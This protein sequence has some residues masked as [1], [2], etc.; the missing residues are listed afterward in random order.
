[1]LD[2]GRVVGGFFILAAL[3]SGPG[4]VLSVRHSTVEPS[5]KTH[6]TDGCMVPSA[7]MRR[8]HPALLA[9]WRMQAVREGTRRIQSADGNT[10]TISLHGTCL[11]C[12]G[13]TTA[14]C[15][16]CHA[17]VGLK[18]TCWQCHT[19]PDVPALQRAQYATGGAFGVP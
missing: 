11:S 18:L 8:E 4:W 10:Y 16:G 14:F 7:R 3:G 6:G 17:E 13:P 2:G 1:M 5:A 12:H 19:A 9:Q 15:D